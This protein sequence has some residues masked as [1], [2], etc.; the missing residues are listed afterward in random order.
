M[1]YY[2]TKVKGAVKLFTVPE[3]LGFAL[4]LEHLRTLSQDGV[5]KLSSE[6]DEVRNQR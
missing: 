6:E 2:A 4:N 5:A 3:E 1:K